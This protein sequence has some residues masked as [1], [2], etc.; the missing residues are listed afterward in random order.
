VVTAGHV[1][2]DDLVDTGSYTVNSKNVKSCCILGYHSAFGGSNYNQVYGV[3]SWL[4]PGLFGRETDIA[5]IS[6]EWGDLVDDPYPYV[7]EVNSAPAWGHVGQ[8]SGCES[9]FEVG[10]PLTG[11]SFAYK[12]NG[13][14]YHLQELAFFGYFYREAGLGTGNKYSF[15]GTFTSYQPTICK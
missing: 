9:N 8:V 1:V 7:N 5:A 15:N 14:V 3:G 4:D 10:D 6:K 13:F 11:T 2:F 12:L